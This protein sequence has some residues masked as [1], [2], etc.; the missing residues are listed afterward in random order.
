MS[1]ETIEQQD[2]R[3]SCR[4]KGMKNKSIAFVSILLVVV[5]FVFLITAG[6]PVIG[7]VALGVS[8]LASALLLYD[9]FTTTNSSQPKSSTHFMSNPMHADFIEDTSHPLV[10]IREFEKD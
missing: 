1:N 2:D 8:L 9:V 3:L 4:K 10:F 6:I 5:G 7:K